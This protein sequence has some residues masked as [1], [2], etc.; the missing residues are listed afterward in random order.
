AS[1]LVNI[2]W[3]YRQYYTIIDGLFY[4]DFNRLW[5]FFGFFEPQNF[6]FKICVLFSVATSDEGEP[7]KISKS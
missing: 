1:F 7:I 4:F 3:W 6:S 5:L 2:G